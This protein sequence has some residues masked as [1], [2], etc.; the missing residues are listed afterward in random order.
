MSSSNDTPRDLS[1]RGAPEEERHPRR[2]YHQGALVGTSTEAYNT[3]HGTPRTLAAQ[4]YLA[5]ALRH[6]KPTTLHQ[7]NTE[8]GA[9]DCCTPESRTGTEEAA[10]SKHEGGLASRGGLD[11]G[12]AR[13]LESTCKS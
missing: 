4:L 3:S 10:I 6:G 9:L 2:L 1:R 11:T 5:A 12:C 7:L 8:N 13:E